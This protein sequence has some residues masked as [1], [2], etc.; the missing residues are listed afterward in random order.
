[1]SCRH[2]VPVTVEVSESAEQHVNGAGS[3][4]L[5]QADFDLAEGDDVWAVAGEETSQGSLSH[6]RT[7]SI[8][9]PDGCREFSLL[10]WIWFEIV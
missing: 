2:R 1:M 6:Q 4:E 8:D 5:L 7:D 3:V 10:S 9:V